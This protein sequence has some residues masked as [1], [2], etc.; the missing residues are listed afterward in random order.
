MGLQ[1]EYKF[2]GVLGKFQM[3]QG[4]YLRPLRRKKGGLADDPGKSTSPSTSEAERT[5]RYTARV[6]GIRNMCPR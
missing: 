3:V 1:L 5:A 2:G 6:T 4:I